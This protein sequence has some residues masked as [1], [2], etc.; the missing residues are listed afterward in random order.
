MRQY[1]WCSVALYPRHIS[2]P[3]LTV[4]PSALLSSHWANPSSWVHGEADKRGEFKPQS[5]LVNYHNQ[6]RWERFPRLPNPSWI[7]FSLSNTRP[8]V[9]SLHF[10]FFHCYFFSCSGI[11]FSVLLCSEYWNI[12]AGIILSSHGD[13][14]WWS[15]LLICYFFMY[16]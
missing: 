16:I 11:Y 7:S 13:T 4:C 8:S 10:T 14:I 2:K 1:F 3:A 12:V 15:T 9:E 5:V 6:G